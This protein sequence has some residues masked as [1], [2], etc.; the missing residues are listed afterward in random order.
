MT[1]DPNGFIDFDDELEGLFDVL[2]PMTHIKAIGDAISGGGRTR[3]ASRRTPGTVAPS[4]AAPIRVST[5]TRTG[6]TPAML[7]TLGRL[8]ATGGIG[9]VV[10][11]GVVRDARDARAAVGIAGAAEPHLD[12]VAETIRVQLAP[13]IGS[14]RDMLDLAEVQR[15]ATSE[16][17][18]LTNQLLTIGDCDD[19]TI[20]IA[21]ILRGF[22]IPIRLK[23]IR[24]KIPDKRTGKQVFVSHIYPQAH[25]GGK[26]QSLESV[27]AVPLGFDPADAY[28]SKGIPI[29]KTDY[30]GDKV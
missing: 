21:Y 27:Q 7:S 6:M 19:K 25:V 3:A 20:L 12:R 29:V 26:W 11:P 22:R 14:I 8:G 24:M 16:H 5:Q 1:Y 23:R 30:I 2:N 17:N 4:G 18:V 9:G 13:Q 15:T 28:Q 10:R